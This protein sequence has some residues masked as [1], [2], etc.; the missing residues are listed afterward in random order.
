M[1]RVER[2]QVG[3]GREQPPQL[4]LRAGAGLVEVR[5]RRCGDLCVNL[6]QKRSEIL[7]AA[8]DERGQCPGRDRRADPVSQQLG[9]P[10][11]GKVLIAH[12]VDAQRPDPRPVLRRRAD[13]G[14]ERSRRNMPTRAPPRV[15]AMLARAQPNLRQIEHLA[16]EMPN[17][18]VV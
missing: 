16:G 14:R 9:S 10:R 7:C 15:R 6:V 8:G 17:I 13:H 12:Q 2:R 11:V 4:A 5:D 1:Q 18:L 3:A